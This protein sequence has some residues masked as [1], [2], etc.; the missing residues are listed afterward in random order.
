MTDLLEVGKNIGIKEKKAKNIAYQIK[1]IV[2]KH[3]LN[4]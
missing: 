4:N 2:D 1:M 3:G